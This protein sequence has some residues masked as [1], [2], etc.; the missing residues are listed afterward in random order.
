MHDNIVRELIPLI[1]QFL[2]ITDMD[3]EI[4]IS[5]VGATSGLVKRHKSIISESEFS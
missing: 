1:L 3:Q 2:K 4:K 5:V